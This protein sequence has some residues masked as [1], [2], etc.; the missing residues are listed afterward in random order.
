MKR[1][2]ARLKR[3]NWKNREKAVNYVSLL[4]RSYITREDETTDWQPWTEN[5]LR[6]SKGSLELSSQGFPEAC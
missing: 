3:D 5:K 6:G 1:R 4:E 2:L